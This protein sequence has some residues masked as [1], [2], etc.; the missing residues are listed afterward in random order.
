MSDEPDQKPNPTGV[1][2]ATNLCVAIV[3]AANA[4]LAGAQISDHF[5]WGAVNIVMV[6]GP[7]VNCTI[8]VLFV[9]LT[10]LVK[11]MA[12]GASI[13]WYVAVAVILPLAFI[14]GQLVPIWLASP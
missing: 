1:M 2:A 3:L 11:N 10:P 6:W 7:I 13:K 14:P 8:L 12:Q 9:A 5:H 4:I